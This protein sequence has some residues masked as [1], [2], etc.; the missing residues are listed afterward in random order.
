M[1]G[2]NFLI[3]HASQNFYNISFQIENR[4]QSLSTN[5]NNDGR[6]EWIYNKNG[7]KVEFEK[8]IWQLKSE[9]M[10]DFRRKEMKDD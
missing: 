8:G 3:Q 6:D 9:Y 10:I 4:K 1:I 5:L 2:P 7:I